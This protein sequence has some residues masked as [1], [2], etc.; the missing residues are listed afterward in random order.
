MLHVS[1]S[2]ILV[3]KCGNFFIGTCSG[4]LSNFIFNPREE[5]QGG[6]LW[7][8]LHKGNGPSSLFVFQIIFE[9]MLIKTN[10]L[11]TY[12]SKMFQTLINS[13]PMFF[14]AALGL[15]AGKQDSI[16]SLFVTRV[17]NRSNIICHHL[18]Q[19]WPLF[20]IMYICFYI[21]INVLKLKIIKE[22]SMESLFLYWIQSEI[23]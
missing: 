2:S 8:V 21:S 16:S 9:Y 5:V 15:Q 13:K 7:T 6:I 4:S 22:E 10:V 1:F 19:K 23:H 11:D 3:N 12:Q 14:F 20:I 18:T 17:I